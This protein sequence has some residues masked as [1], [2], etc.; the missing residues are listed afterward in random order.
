[1]IIRDDSQTS[2]KLTAPGILGPYDEDSRLELTC[3]AESDE[4]QASIS[5]WHLKSISAIRPTTVHYGANNNDNNNHAHFNA[6]NKPAEQHLMAT[7]TTRGAGG[8]NNHNNYLT[9]MTLNSNGAASSLE[10]DR[11]SHDED[12]VEIS[13]DYFV[14]F[15]SLLPSTNSIAQL[16][17]QQDLILPFQDGHRLKHWLRVPDQSINNLISSDNKL[18]T[19]LHVSLTRSNIGD[20]YICLASS[21]EN[22]IPLNITTKINLNRKYFCLLR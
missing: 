15:H 16:Q 19:S 13:R 12:N 22:S 7:T 9:T 18:Q 17:Q 11:F 2:Q 14:A 21:K 10:G 20:E 5:W 6:N 4:P 8:D 1:M 3:E